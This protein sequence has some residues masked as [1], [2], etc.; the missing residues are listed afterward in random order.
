MPSISDEK[1]IKT[2]VNVAGGVIMRNG[3]N[4][5]QQ[6][7]LIRRAP[8]DHWPLHYEFPRGKCDNGP[9]EKL[10][11]CMKR[12]IKEETGLDVVPIR[13]IDKFEYIADRGTRKSTQY[14]FLCKMKD[15]NQKIKLSKEHAG[16][17]KDDKGYR[18]VTSFGEVELMV[19]PE[20][21][22]TI[23]KVFNTHMRSVVYGNQQS[24]KEDTISRYL[25]DIQC[26]DEGIGNFLR[27][28][29]DLTLKKISMNLKIA[30]GL[31]SIHAVF[32]KVPI[33]SIDKIKRNA[34]KEIPGFHESYKVSSRFMKSLRNFPSEL[35]DGFATI[36]AIG[37]N[38]GNSK[39]QKKNMMKMQKT[40]K[41]SIPPSGSGS[42]GV[43]SVT[44]IALGLSALAHLIFSFVSAGS[45][46]R[47]VGYVFLIFAAVVYKAVE[48][49]QRVLEM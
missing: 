8:D 10:I 18:W 47:I 11:D 17:N 29:N 38:V 28:V 22:K 15:P 40:V 7:L 46:Q 33:A 26:L 45:A 5:E 12:E 44:A 31:D 3:E 42:A 43:A 48:Y 4:D 16:M 2:Y 39:D 20:C 37:S 41:K 25:N 21:K 35:K 27:K 13:F 49:R 14:N 23:S 36:L 19:M 34:S 6:I 9:S 24:M 30:M 1:K 32:D